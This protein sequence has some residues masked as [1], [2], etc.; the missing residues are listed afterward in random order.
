MLRLEREGKSLQRSRGRENMAELT[1]AVRT[2]HLLPSG[3]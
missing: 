1:A 3:E 2:P